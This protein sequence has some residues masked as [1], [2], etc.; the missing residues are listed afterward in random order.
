MIYN[1]LQNK[2]VR[3]PVYS[4]LN[5]I[6]LTIINFLNTINQKDNYNATDF[7]R[8]RKSYT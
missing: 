5:K 2:T 6:L 3:L 7:K 8:H 1:L 4:A